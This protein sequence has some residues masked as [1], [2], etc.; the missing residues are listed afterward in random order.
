MEWNS[1]NVVDD[2]LPKKDFVNIKIPK[3][4][5]NYERLTTLVEFYIRNDV[6]WI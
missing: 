1:F 5:I 3:V 2:Y 6:E 4:F